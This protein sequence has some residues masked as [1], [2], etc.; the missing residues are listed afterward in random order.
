MLETLNKIVY[1]I[2][3]NHMNYPPFVTLLK[4]MEDYLMIFYFLFFTSVHGTSTCKKI[5]KSRHR[6]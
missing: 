4:E 1:C 3:A 2:Y 6:L 5:N